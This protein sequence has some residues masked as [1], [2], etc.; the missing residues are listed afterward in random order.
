M[1]EKSIDELHLSPSFNNPLSQRIIYFLLFIV[2]ICF[3]IYSYKIGGSKRE[4]QASVGYFATIAQILTLYLVILGLIRFTYCLSTLN[5]LIITLIPTF[6]ILFFYYIITGERGD[7]FRFGIC[8]F[9]IFY[10]F[11]KK[12]PFVKLC[13]LVFLGV[14]VLPITQAFKSVLLTGGD[15]LIYTFNGIFFGEFSSASRNL[16]LIVKHGQLDNGLFLIVGDIFRAMIPFS[17]NLGFSSSVSWYHFIYRPHFGF[18]GDV[19][20]GLGL[21]P[22][23]VLIGGY[24]GTS[25]IFSILGLVSYLFYIKRTNGILYYVFYFV[26]IT[27]L[28]YCLRADIANLLSIS[29]KIV[30]ALYLC[31][32]LAK[33]FLKRRISDRT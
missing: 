28:I 32:F 15:G 11:K 7:L 20:W 2:T 19:G 8:I 9:L 17:S 5:N 21:V 18:G 13:F 29:F 24:I 16:Y 22:Q 26:F 25:I 3:C 12:V 33:F 10:D 14:L 23:A 31:L 4:L 27:T 6:F 30:F 1:K